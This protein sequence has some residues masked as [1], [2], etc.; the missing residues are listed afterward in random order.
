MDEW[1]LSELV[2][3]AGVHIARLP[4]PKN[5]QVRAVPDERTVRYYGTLGLL[6]R[7]ASMRGRTALYSRRHLAQVVAIKR[8]QSAGRSLADI[9]A[10]WSSL[11]DQTL[12]RM[13]GIDVPR[14][15]STQRE[16]WKK[17]P[18]VV[19]APPP[20]AVEEHAPVELRVELAPGVA[21]VVA[22][23]GGLQITPADVRAIRAAASPLLLELDRLANAKTK[24]NV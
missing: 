7:P 6:D 1:T 15:T 9:Q 4:A 2:A 13:T 24:E 3:Q 21:I 14:A 11:D 17:P 8:L 19:V 23:A 12:A 5:G 10:L 16:F 22:L 18:E 20:P